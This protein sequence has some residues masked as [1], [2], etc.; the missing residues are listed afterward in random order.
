V[1]SISLLSKNNEIKDLITKTLEFAKKLDLEPIISFYFEQK[2]L[3]DIIKK[4]DSQFSTLYE[5]YKFF[6]DV[7]ITEA[8][9]LQNYDFKGKYIEY[10]YYTIPIG[11]EIEIMFVRNNWIPPKAVILRGQ[12][13]FTFMPHATFK[14]VEESIRTQNEDDITVDFLNGIPAKW[15]R[16]R[17]IFTDF[18]NTSEVLQ[19][20]KP[21][22]VNFA[23]TLETYLLVGIIANNVYPEKNKVIVRRRGESLEYEIVSGKASREEVRRGETLDP[24]SKAE[25]Y[26]DFKSRSI[27]SETL[28]KGLI[29]KLPG[30]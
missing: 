5:K 18:R 27:D 29:Y 28:I 1:E 26:Y 16:K 12:V 9:K 23:P 13:K 19:S 10:I 6:R 22:L 30:F 25:L 15:E 21:V 20:K 8:L 17:N 3:K 2:L 4:L 24:I 14:E 11:D 7:F